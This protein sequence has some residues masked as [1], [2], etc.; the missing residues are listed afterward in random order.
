MS[1]F[2]YQCQE[3]A[4]N[5]GCTVK[6]VCGKNE[7]VAKLQDLLIYTCKGISEIVVK[8]NLDVKA[9]G[10]INHQVLKS[11][12]ITITNANFDENAIES[13]INKMLAYRDQLKLKA[14]E[15]SWSDA[16][17]FTVTDRSSMVE[18]AEDVGVLAT[19]NE[20]IRSLR[21]LITYG[22]KGMAAYT[23]H[24]LNIGKE[25][26]DIYEFVYKALASI[27]DD[28]LSLDDLVALTLKTGEYGVAAM[29]LLDEANTSK[30]G[31]PE[32]TTV[33]IGVKIILVF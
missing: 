18:K 28:S 31:N 13:Q 27:I 11:L 16:A 23:H 4:R 9:L 20:D 30:Y 14:G 10:D 22:L 7:D 15:K 6:G 8:E 26:T 19:E 21:E 5:N 17:T 29:A 33:D 12:F 25:N 32:I 2:C 3:T 1:M 24:A